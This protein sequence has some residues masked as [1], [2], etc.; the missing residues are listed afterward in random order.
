MD[1][2]QPGKYIVKS[3]EYS[4]E[5]TMP[6]LTA[7]K[8]FILGYTNEI[9]GIYKASDENPV[10]IFDDFTTSKHWVNFDFKVKSS[11]MKM[12]RIKDNVDVVFR[13]AYYAI[14][15]I[16]YKPQDHTRQWISTYS[17]FKI[18]VPKVA[19]QKRIVNILDKFDSLI[20]D[21][22]IGLP[23][24]ISARKSQYEYYRTK[25]LTF[26]EYAN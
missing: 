11:A 9:N 14:K 1:Y 16:Q 12:L 8:T 25:L 5:H 2:E 6:V 10:I 3:T 4:N 24:E 19:E 26:N 15:C 23:A 7:G 18:P 20:N 21:I 13:Y 22:S 17:E